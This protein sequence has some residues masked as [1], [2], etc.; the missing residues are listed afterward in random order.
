MNLKTKITSQTNQLNKTFFFS[1]IEKKT[2]CP[3][4][5]VSEPN[6]K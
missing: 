5:S 2:F 1:F 6:T 4:I 3:L